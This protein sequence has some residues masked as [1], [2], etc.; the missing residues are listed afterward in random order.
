VAGAAAGLVLAVTP[1]VVAMSRHNNPDALVALVSTGAL[2]CIVRGLEDGRTRWLVWAGVC[3]GLGFEAK[4]G[5]ALLVVPALAAAWLWVAPRGRLAAV[6][7]LAAGGVAMVIVGGAWPLLM[8]LT[9]ASQ[10]PWISGTNDNSILS[11]IVGYNGLGRLDGQAGGPQI[12]GGGGSANSLFGGASGPLRLLNQALGGQAGWLLGFA[13]VSGLAVLA[14]SRLRRDDPRTGWLIA[15]GGAF[16]TIAVAFS[17]AAGIFHPYYVSLLAPFIAVLVG[18][19]VAQL[20]ERGLAATILA[21]LAVAAGVLCEVKILRDNSGSLTW[22]PPLLLTGGIG[23]AAVL[24]NVTRPRMRLAALAAALALLL[25]A[26]ATWAAQTLGHATNGTFPAGGPAA[27][28]FGGPGGG[29]R[30]AGG[31]GGM[32]GGDSQ[33]L[34]AAVTY[35]AAHGGGTVAVSSQTDAASPIIASGA[36]VAGIGGFSGRESAVTVS[37]L[38]DAVQS[39]RI[40]WVLT[41]TGGGFGGPGND[42]RTGATT[43]MAAVQRSCTPVSAVSGLYDC[44]GQAASLSAS[45]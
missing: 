29:G 18:A 23:A 3:V 41:T 7:Q 11:L 28:S 45:S 8:A 25:V 42:S 5:A 31:G 9:P 16:L 40:R 26:P 17:A 2:W 32:F 22:L 44:S 36:D 43:A 39:G 34:T 20:A 27:A 35:A 24:A 38:A 30:F 33:G 10:R 19:G 21:P 15:S 13:L 4:M 12:M 37:W 14:A 1:I 6:R